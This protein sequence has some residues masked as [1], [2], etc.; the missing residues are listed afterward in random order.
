MVYF[1]GFLSNMT[2][3]NSKMIFAAAFLLLWGVEAQTQNEAEKDWLESYYEAPDPDQ[4][5]QQ[6][7]NWASEGVLDNEHAKPALIAFTSQL[8]RQ[9]KEKVADWYERLSGLAPQQMQVLHTAMLYS[10]TTEADAIMQEKFGTRYEE[11]KRE[12]KKILELPL[13]KEA[14]ADMLWGF[15]YATG[16]EHAIRRVVLCF[17]FEDA[18]DNPEGVDV[19]EGYVPHYKRLPIFA[20]N[21]LIAN[22]ER[23][24]R[25]VEILEKMLKEDTSL[26]DLE[27]E[28]VYNVLSVLKPDV[29]PDRKEAEKV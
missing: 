29:Y 21:S 6:M 9:N 7:K 3:K 13:D 12:T 26:T 15:Y 4:F 1:H 16:S 17:R 23:H 22:G 11:Q 28:G 20:E 5:V 24:P 2:F 18:P 10:R 19:P 8:I 25:V 14:T 27:K